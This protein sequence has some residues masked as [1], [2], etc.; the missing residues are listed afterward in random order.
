MTTAPA[1]AI[2]GRTLFLVCAYAARPA[3]SIA[4]RFPATGRLGRLADRLT[5]HSLRSFIAA[6]RDVAANP[7]SLD[8]QLAQVE[9]ALADAA[10]GAATIFVDVAL[11]AAPPTSMPA[12]RVESREP[13]ALSAA[14]LHGFAEIVLVYPD[15]LGLGRGSL[16]AGL[17]RRTACPIRILNGRRRTMPLSPENRRALRWRRILAATRA[18]ELG[19]SLL[20]IPLAA[21]WA[22]RDALRGRS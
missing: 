6:A 9:E 15:A 22:L 7:R 2:P 21:A 13:E 4:G 8:Y 18:T 11:A 14:D 5:G 1:P 3:F 16:E 10:D 17:R 19:L 20:V 12:A